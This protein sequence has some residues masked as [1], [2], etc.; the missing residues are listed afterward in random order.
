GSD[1]TR[2]RHLTSEY[3]ST[4]TWEGREILKVEPEGLAALAREAFRDV[5]FLYRASHLAKVAAILDDPDAS[6]NDRGVALA[7]LRNAVVASGFRLPMCQDT[8]TA[9]IVAKKG[10]H[11]WTGLEDEEWLSR[12]IFETYQ[13]EN[14]RYSQTIPLSL[15]EEVNSGTNL[16]AQIDIYATN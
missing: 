12:G 1:T 11:V 7:L 5:S 8:G 13:K 9:T 14:L 3:V 2:Y 4:A 15:Y 10:Q 16:P 6:P